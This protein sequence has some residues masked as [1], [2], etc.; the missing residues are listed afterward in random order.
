MQNGIEYAILLNLDTNLLLDL[1]FKG[2]APWI[3]V[4]TIGGN[5]SKLRQEVLQDFDFVEWFKDKAETFL[6]NLATK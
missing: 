2:Y 4:T 6:K 5:L 3:G 1:Y